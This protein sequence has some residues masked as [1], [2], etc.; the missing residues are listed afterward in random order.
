MKTVEPFAQLTSLGVSK[1]N[2]I[3]DLQLRGRGTAQR[4]LHL[5]G[6]FCPEQ[7]KVPWHPRERLASPT[8]WP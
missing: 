5:A 8:R 2:L 1:P 4:G 6:T 3:T 7:L